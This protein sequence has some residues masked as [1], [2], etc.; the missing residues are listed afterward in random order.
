M[1]ACHYGGLVTVP[2]AAQATISHVIHVLRSTSLKVLVID[3]SHLESVLSFINETTVK[4]IVVIGDIEAYTVNNIGIV[5]LEYVAVHGEEGSIE[6]LEI[7]K[8]F[9]ETTTVCFLHIKTTLQ[10]TAPNAIASIYY[11][12]NLKNQVEYIIDKLETGLVNSTECL[13]FNDLGLCF[14]LQTEI[15]ENPGIVLSHKVRKIKEEAYQKLNNNNHFLNHR[16]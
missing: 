15:D 16:T 12:S 3:E 9:N 11:S 8:F 4:F 6:S 13:Y 2:I 14:F 1:S 5:S 7:S 10:F